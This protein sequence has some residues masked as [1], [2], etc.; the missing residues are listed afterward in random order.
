MLNVPSMPQDLMEFATLPSIEVLCAVRRA[1]AE[2]WA[3]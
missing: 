1:H 3:W 2:L